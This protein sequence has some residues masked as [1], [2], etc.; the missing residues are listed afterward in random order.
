VRYQL[1]DHVLVM[2]VS[3]VIYDVIVVFFVLIVLVFWRWVLLV[4]K[5]WVWSGV[6]LWLSSFRRLV[7]VASRPFPISWHDGSW[8]DWG[9]LWLL[10]LFS[11]NRP[12]LI[13]VTVISRCW[14]CNLYLWDTNLG[15]TRQDQT[16]VR[17]V[18]CTSSGFVERCTSMP[19]REP[20]EDFSNIMTVSAYYS[21]KEDTKEREENTELPSQHHSISSLV[22]QAFSLILCAIVARYS[23]P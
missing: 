12:L 10:A 15:K 9:W 3:G 7:A 21:G 2:V 22:C 20:V 18:R 4:A 14:E 11:V 23:R 6:S 13:W 1:V 16:D 19:L 5:G 8:M 17:M